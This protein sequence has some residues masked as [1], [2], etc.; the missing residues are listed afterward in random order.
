MQTQY[1]IAIIWLAGFLLSYWMLKVEHEA[2]AENYTNGEKALQV[3]L[4]ILSMAMVLFLLVNAWQ[5]S[6][7]KFWKKPLVNK[8]TE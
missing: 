3:L 6:V 8:K 4:S 2:E 1:I 5:Q 7:Q